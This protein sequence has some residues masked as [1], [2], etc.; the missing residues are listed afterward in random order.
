LVIIIILLVAVF[1]FTD[2]RADLAFMVH[3][4]SAPNHFTYSGH[5]DYVSAVAWSPDGKRIAS[6]SGD[7]TVQVWDAVGGGHVLTF[8]GHSS[9]VACLSWSADGKYIVSG[10]IDG[11]ILVWDATSGNRIYMYEGHSDAVFGVAW[12]PDGKRIASASNDGSVQ[13]WDA[14]TGTHVISHLSALNSRLTRAPWNA[15]AWSP[16]GKHVAI[17]GVG[18]AI[19]LDATT[20]AIKAYYGYHGGSAHALAWSPDGI[21]LAVGRDDTTVQVW[22]VAS[23]VNVYTFMG[24]SADVL[25]VAW[26]PDGKRI[27]SGDSD[28]LVLVWDA[29]TGNHVYTYRG[30][31]DFYPGHFTS[32]KAVNTAA[33]SPDGKS[34][35]SGSDD[36]TVQVWQAK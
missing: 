23:T 16:D 11:K 22:N 18:D 32:G 10:S 6:A 20:G 17:G 12:S 1:V 13:I 4:V 8:R 24:H 5:S 28:G 14:F 33:W 27:A 9:D 25:T 34:I 7:H 19:V 35:A 15:V 30:H 2:V 29:L 36:M 3:F 21:Y 31:A 26:S